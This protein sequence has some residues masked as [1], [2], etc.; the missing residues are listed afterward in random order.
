MHLADI[1]SWF[2]DKLTILK[3]LPGY[4]GNDLRSDLLAGLTVGLMLI[5]QGMAYAV[6]AGLSPI[7]GLYGAL[8]PLL[9]FPLFTTSRQLAVGIV[10]TDMIIIAAGASAIAMP[11]TEKYISVV[12]LLTAL[13][14]IVHLALSLVKPGFIVNLMSKPVIYG[15]M[16]AAPIIISFSQLGNLMGIDLDYSQYILVILGELYHRID[17]INLITLAIGLFGIVFI[18]IAKKYKPLFPKSLALL[19]ICIAVVAGFD[20]HRQDLRIV[21]EIPSGLPGFQL[22][23]FTS[24]DVRRLIPTVIT[25]VI[26]QM[27]SVVSLGKTYANKYRYPLNT[28]KEFLALGAANFVSSFFQSPP[29]SASF[30]RTV[31]NDEAGARTSLSNVF[32]ACLVGLTLLFLTPLF[33]F[34]P[35]S[36]LAAI[37]I[38]ATLSL[39][40]I[41]ELLYLLRTKREDG[42]IAIFT[43]A[44]VLFIG[45]QEGI[46]MGIGASLLFMLYR[47]S[48][49]RIVVL[50]HVKGSR[51][52]RDVDR[53]PEARQI[54]GIM[55]LRLDD[56]FTFHNA[57]YFKEYLVHQAGEQDQD[58]EAVVIEGRSIND[59]DTT[60][61]EA[62][63]MA[64]DNLHD[65][66]VDLHF[67]GLKGTVRDIMMRSGMA[68][69]LGGTH[70]H[71]TT[72]DA[73]KYILEKS[74]QR[75]NTDNRLE[76]YMKT[77]S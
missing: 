24:E 47:A 64:V 29:A 72:H 56:S 23:E 16:V 66:D 28:G 41:G 54:P 42:Y 33:Y 15:F 9:I 17:E 7:Y 70:F 46:L 75:D 43:I 74:R 22:H 12:L 6:I 39:V 37:I 35:L 34:I 59:L 21:G 62:L 60:A 50:G 68:R 49:P 2:R 31:V 76:E 11:G 4:T 38:V 30:S 26:V 27:M 44:S 73:V 25:L 61:I 69:R 36:A 18:I 57:E 5:P 67:A 58:I 40:N 19:A 55:I 32:S 1:A 10:A 65:L 77:V 8:V 53:K 13:V 71:M 51:F 45:I 20:L 3:W 63:G 48:H 52:F 14:G